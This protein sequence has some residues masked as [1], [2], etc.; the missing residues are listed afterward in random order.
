MRQTGNVRRVADAACLP[1]VLL[2]VAIGLGACT[3]LPIGSSSPQVASRGEPAVTRETAQQ[4]TQRIKAQRESAAR[5]GVVV[6]SAGASSL[7]GKVTLKLVPVSPSG[8]AQ[9]LTIGLNCQ[10]NCLARQVRIGGT[11]M[12]TRN[13]LMVAQLAPGRWQIGEVRYARAIVQPAK[14]SP[15]EVRNGYATYLGGFFVRPGDTAQPGVRVFR[16]AAMQQDMTRALSAYPAVRG[17]RMINTVNK[18][19]QPELLH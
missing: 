16:Y 14:Q 10:P 6:L 5:S 15:F 19:R 11:R 3:G 2:G 9:W 1:I 17:R 4:E 13:T 7:S 18:L 8:K 12:T